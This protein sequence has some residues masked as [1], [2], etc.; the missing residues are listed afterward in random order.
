MCGVDSSGTIH[1]LLVAVA[2]EDRVITCPNKIPGKGNFEEIAS[3]KVKIIH[4]QKYQILPYYG[5]YFRYY[6][7]IQ[8]SP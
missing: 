6:E 8:K 4:F 3:Q 2:S 7:E 1:L 5:S